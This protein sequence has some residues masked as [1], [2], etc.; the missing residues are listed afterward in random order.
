M[1]F[2]R[3]TTVTIPSSGSVKGSYELN[4]YSLGMDNFT[5]NDKMPVKNGGSNFWRLAQDA[6]IDTLG[7]YSKRQG[8]DYHSEA[9]GTTEDQSQTDTTGADTQSFSVVDWVAQP[10]TTVSAGALTRLD[11]SLENP[12]GGVGTVAVEVWTDDGGEPGEKL[13]KSSLA[14]SELP[15]TSDYRTVHFARAPSLGAST[16]YWIVVY[17]QPSSSSSYEITTTTDGSD[18]L[19]SSNSG[20][21]WTPTSFDI[22]FRQYYASVE[23]VKGLLR[24]YKS[25]GTRITIF[26]HDTSL[27]TVDE[28]TGALTAIKTGLSASATHY[29][30]TI[31]ND[32]LYYVNGFDGYRKWDFTTE[33]QV[34]ATNYT[35][36]EEHKGIIFLTRADDPNRIDYSN[37]AEYETFTSTDF[38]YVPSP[39]TGDP[40]TAIISINGYLCIFTLNRK[41]ILSGDDNA[42]FNLDEAPDL[43]GTYTKETVT[44]DKN[45]MYY[46]SDDGVYR[47]NGSEAQLMSESIYGSILSLQ[48]KDRACICISGG[49]VYLWHSLPGSS[50]NNR[51]WVFNINYGGSGGKDCVESYDTD[52]FVARA[53]NA[54][55]E[56]RL[57]VGSSVLGQVYWQELDSNDY[58]N[59][60][61]D[62]NYMLA[63]H[64]ITFSAPAV[65][66]EVRYLQSRFEASSDVYN[67]DIEY[68]YDLRDNWSILALQPLQG[69]GYIWG[70][71]DTIWGQFIW[72]TTSEHQSRLYI[73]GEYRRIAIRYKNFMA[74]QPVTFLGQSIV[75]Q[76]RRMR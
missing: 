58:C 42:T 34:N 59:L 68:A 20:L 14:S 67:V 11:I 13:A 33:S 43:K 36:I 48:N 63:S 76:T 69:E 38:I 4:D 10:F 71:P 5:S 62:I 47:S 61:G 26:A 7:E 44:K 18:A 55:Q 41:Y 57:L 23:G 19:V 24:A 72:G 21:S 65:L 12:N 60:G 51:C 32:L 54:F 17:I 28:V 37:F 73:P 74:R 40:T 49:Q 1:P 30:F 15:L 16:T 25:D 39:K 53:V 31:V 50:F 22:N 70:D 2:A 6:R 27:Y 3:R 46:L 9:V 75:Y 56:E 45:F 66:K 8:F 52:A 35:D 64:Y 29:R